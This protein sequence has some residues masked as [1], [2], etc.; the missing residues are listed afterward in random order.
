M[1]TIATPKSRAIAAPFTILPVSFH[2]ADTSSPFIPWIAIVI[3]AT[4]MNTMPGFQRIAQFQLS[5]RIA[6]DLPVPTV[7]AFIALAQPIPLF[8]HTR[9]STRTMMMMM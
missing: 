6:P 4:M 8:W 3:R 7:K 9:V 1:L 5:P 2:A